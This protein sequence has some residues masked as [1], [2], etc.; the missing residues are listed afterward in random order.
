MSK[1]ASRCEH[2][3]RLDFLSVDTFDG[4]RMEGGREE[5]EGKKTSAGKIM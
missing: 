4:H 3:R 2:D 1:E 5:G